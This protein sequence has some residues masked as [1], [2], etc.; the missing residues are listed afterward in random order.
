M[1]SS[2]EHAHAEGTTRVFMVVWFWLLALT[3][4]EVFLGYKQ[5]ELKLRSTN[6]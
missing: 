1:S 6:N 5:F 4:V 3:G 2:I